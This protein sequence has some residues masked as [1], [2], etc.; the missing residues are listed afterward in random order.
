MEEVNERGCWKRLWKRFVKE[1]VGRGC[2]SGGE[3]EELLGVEEVWLWKKRGWKRVIEKDV[4]VE[5]LEVD[6]LLFLIL[7]V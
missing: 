3:E 4:V 5:E 2:G 7:D 6:V 1:G